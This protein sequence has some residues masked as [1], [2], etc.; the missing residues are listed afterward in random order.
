M[1]KEFLSKIQ[2]ERLKKLD[3]I[4][5]SCS[6]H[7]NFGQ[8]F[9]IEHMIPNDQILHLDGE[10]E[11]LTIGDFTHGAFNTKE[12]LKLPFYQIARI[13]NGLGLKPF[14]KESLKEFILSIPDE[15][16]LLLKVIGTKIIQSAF[17]DK[18]SVIYTFEIIDESMYSSM[19]NRD[20]SLIKADIEQKNSRSNF[21]TDRWPPIAKID[22]SNALKLIIKHKGLEVL[23]NDR[24]NYI[25]KDIVD[26]S[27]CPAAYCILR[28]FSFNN[29]F[30]KMTKDSQSKT[31]YHL[32]II[33]QRAINE[34]GFSPIVVDYVIESFAKALNI[35]N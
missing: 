7:G 2:S 22:L 33:R 23:T 3:K 17:T 18:K 20:K 6:S 14:L 5:S 34:L 16:Y 15:G 35:I 4:L 31:N 8:L 24:L 25:L 21:Q 29:L 28:E 9:D 11:Q 30:Y 13:N 32:N 26:F 1:K 27:N 10:I 12:G 19:L